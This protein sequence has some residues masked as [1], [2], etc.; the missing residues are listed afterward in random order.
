M[1]KE[2]KRGFQ[3]RKN[4]KSDQNQDRKPNLNKTSQR[5]EKLYKSELYMPHKKRKEY[6]KS[7]E[8]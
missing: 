8:K 3:Y 2:T 6:T 4:K 7:N 1:N 5:A